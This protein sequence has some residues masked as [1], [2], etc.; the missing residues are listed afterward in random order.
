MACNVCLWAADD[1]HNRFFVASEV[2]AR[3]SHECCECR[4]PIPSGSRYRREVGKS[5]DGEMF[6][7]KTCVICAEIRDVFTCGNAFYFTTLWDEMEQQAFPELTTASEC[8]V[9]LSPAAKAVVMDRWRAW[10]GLP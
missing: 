3:T 6:S 7:Y 5:D 9:D 2:R 8:F 1:V 4:Q 10:K